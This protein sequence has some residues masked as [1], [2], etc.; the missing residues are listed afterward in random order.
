MHWEPGKFLQEFLHVCI[1]GYSY[2]YKYWFLLQK[3]LSALGSFAFPLM[4]YWSRFFYQIKGSQLTIRWKKNVIHPSLLC[5]C[6]CG[7][8]PV[9]VMVN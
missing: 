9:A 1:F 8:S 4:T 5:T 2:I 3:C 7:G 6:S